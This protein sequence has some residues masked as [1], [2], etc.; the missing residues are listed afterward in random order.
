MQDRSTAVLFGDGAGGVLLEASEQQHFLAEALH[1]DGAQGQS[2]TSGQSSLR[3]PFSQG[4]EVNSFLQMDGRAIFDFAIRDVS[5]SITAIIEQ[6]GLAKEE[7]D[8]LLLHQA[9]S[10]YFR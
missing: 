2:L 10:A 3:S 9:T 1:T 8:Y 4:Q 5:R 7:L 6:S